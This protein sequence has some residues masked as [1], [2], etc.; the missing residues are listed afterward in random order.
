MDIFCKAKA[1]RF[2]SH[3]DKY[4][5]ADDD[6][7]NTRQSRNGS[8]RKSRWLV[9]LVEGNNHLI[10]LKSCHGKYL[11][12]SD[13]AFL[14][15][16][17]GNKV[18]Q[19]SPENTNDLRIEWEPIRDGFQVKL[20][21]FGGRYLRANGGTPPWRNSVT[22]DSPHTASTH[23]WILWNVETVDI[24]EN[25]MLTDY[26]SMVSSFS[27]VS[28]E[29]SG[30]DMGSPVM[31][32]RSS[33]SSSPKI[34]KSIIKKP[35]MDLFYKAKAVRLRS[36]H[37]K[38]LTAEED[39]ETVIQ[40]RDGASKNATWTVEF[41]NNNS[42]KNIIR[43]KSFYG[44]YLTASNQRFLLGMTG[45]KVLQTLPK[46]LDSSV[47]WEPIREGNQ[48]KLKTRYGQFLRANDSI[49]PWR[50][51]VT[52]NIPHRTSTQ[53]WVLWDVDVVEI[54][55]HSPAPKPPPPLIPHEES[56]A[57]SESSSPSFVSSASP[58][59][60]SR[61]ESGEFLASSLMKFGDGRL[62][63]YHIADEY[64]EI[65]E[66]VEGLCIP[67]KGNSV[68]ELTKTLE[69]ETGLEDI[70][71]CT[72]SPLNGKLYPLRLQLPPNNAN[73]DVIVVPSGLI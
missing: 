69:E 44:K 43:L 52:H 17:T 11:L 29:L 16:M 68:E 22:H 8:S 50:N 31:S 49:P 18:T 65:N 28:D 5:V 3:L 39:E 38:Y 42:E 6:Q 55:V 60:F 34:P 53:D 67:F 10:R 32:T 1:V 41:I 54:L 59:S 72:K 33:F 48:V 25:E 2:K 19:T 46:R 57:A 4:L 13:V 7:E 30:L 26:L 73:M 63:Y 70:T 15:G 40:D 24:P 47:E 35:A 64:G 66:G 20:K 56:V 58:A 37:D 36:Y 27:S 14:L 61:Q 62:I 71:V 45:R 9:E 51:S 23:N 21:A 12:A